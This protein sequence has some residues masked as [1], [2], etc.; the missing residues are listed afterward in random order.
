MEKSENLRKRFLPF[1]SYNLFLIWE[2]TLKLEDSGT[3]FIVKC[4]GHKL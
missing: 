1:K 4:V 3:E 2:N